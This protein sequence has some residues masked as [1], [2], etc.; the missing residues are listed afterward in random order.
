MLRLRA[1]LGIRDLGFVRSGLARLV[2]GANPES[3]ESR[4]PPPPNPQSRVPI[5]K[6][7]ESQIPNPESQV[8]TPEA[9]ESRIPNPESRGDIF[10]RCPPGWAAFA[11]AQLHSR[12]PPHL[13]RRWLR[14]SP[15]R[16]PPT[17][18][19]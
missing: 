3:R 1:E 13:L 9:R 11:C 8:Q 4:I 12:L 10:R 17:T 5:P 15:D 16:P 2:R 6:P 7:R 19:C 18:C 14:N